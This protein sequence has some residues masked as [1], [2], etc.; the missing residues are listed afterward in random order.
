[1]SVCP[2]PSSEGGGVSFRAVSESLTR[3]ASDETPL[4]RASERSILVRAGAV[5]QRAIPG[6][7]VGKG[8]IMVAIAS[9]VA[10][11]AA[12]QATTRPDWLPM[13]DFRTKIDYV[14][15]YEDQVRGDF[16]PA[17][18][19]YPLYARI[20]PEFQDGAT[21]KPAGLQFSGFRHGEDW[22]SLIG[23][24]DPREHP[25]W[26]ASYQRTKATL[27]MFK[28]AAARPYCLF[29]PQFSQGVGDD[30]PRLLP[31]LLL[32]HLSHFRACAKGLSEA[33]WRAENGKIDPGP[34]LDSCRARLQACK[35]LERE[36]LLISHLVSLKIRGTVYEDLLCALCCEVFS[37][38]DRMRATEMLDRADTGIEPLERAMRADS[39]GSFDLLQYVTRAPSAWRGPSIARA[40]YERMARLI[41]SIDDWPAG[42]R[43]VS[44]AEIKA[45]DPVETAQ[46]LRRFFGEL[47]MMMHKGYPKVTGGDIERRS[48]EYARV[49][50]FTGRFLASYTRVYVLH[51]GAQAQRRATRLVYELHIY[52]D[53]YAR[54]PKKLDELPK[55]VSSRF[56]TDPFSGKLFIYRLVQGKPLLY[57]VSVNGLD[58][59]GQ[60]DNSWSSGEAGAPGEYVFWPIQLNSSP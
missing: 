52:R 37:S 6:L 2:A 48:A 58:D 51:T 49:N 60:H 3:V 36:R 55:D 20:F 12:G 10:V 59:G 34:F 1:M 5:S 39:A 35:Q 18:N 21:S 24:W 31:L 11:L 50:G 53:R 19:A 38:N 30:E 47:A 32:P 13:P 56:R 9:L 14:K 40:R 25:E 42:A 54:W 4:N 45:I 16:D 44:R 22:R 41:V 15:W 23:P 26:E 43:Q 29:P 33:A 17:D 28:H 7:R 8:R 46:V 57:S 27:K